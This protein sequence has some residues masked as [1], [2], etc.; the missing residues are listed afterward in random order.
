MKRVLTE[1]EQDYL[2][3]AVRSNVAAKVG[4][5]TACQLVERAERR[6]WQQIRTL[7]PEASRIDTPEDDVWS[8]SI[9]PKMGEIK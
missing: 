6:L 5:T 3:A 7:F 8:V 1:D 9:P 2:E 4:F